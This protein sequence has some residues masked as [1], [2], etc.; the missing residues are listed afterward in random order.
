VKTWSL[1]PAYYIMVVALLAVL[2]GPVTAQASTG[3][4]SKT[5]QGQTAQTRPVGWIGIRGELQYT[6]APRP[7]QSA[8][9]VL[10]VD[11]S[12]GSPA[13]L[14][15]VR[16]GD[17]IVGLLGEPL[18]YDAWVRSLAGLVPGDSLKITLLR[19]SR[20]AQI[21]LHAGPRPTA[22]DQ[23]TIVIHQRVRT[24]GVLLA[25][26]ADS[27]VSL[28]EA[29]RP[30]RRTPRTLFGRNGSFEI[31]SGTPRSPAPPA[32]SD[33][34]PLF[35]PRPDSSSFDAS[36]ERPSPLRL[37]RAGGQPMES[38]GT[39]IRMLTRIVTG[40]AHFILG[41]VR[42]TTASPEFLAEAGAASG[43]L[44]VDVFAD[45]PAARIGFQPGDLIISVA[46]NVTPNP[47]VLGQAIAAA[48]RPFRLQVIRNGTV[49]TMN[50]R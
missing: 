30:I 35:L 17:R 41:G 23:G 49:E 6:T 46:G 48:I 19:G 2:P 47:A 44:I 20:S 40:Q 24:L 12:G 18:T 15:D 27:L 14:A 37:Q 7:G 36:G 10:V 22:L 25:R 26:G 16:P 45:S 9:S 33:L 28:F 34:G 21:L 3:R 5:P 1:G 4:I 42:A 38:R 32:P 50:F 43:V 31:V 8:W 11:I 39:R 13:A 29:T